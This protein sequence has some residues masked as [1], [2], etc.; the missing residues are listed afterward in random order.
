MKEKN[1]KE[2]RPIAYPLPSDSDRQVQNQPEY[3]DQE[4]NK[5]EKEVSDVEVKEDDKKK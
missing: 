1:K 5:F 4:P 2:E 3:I